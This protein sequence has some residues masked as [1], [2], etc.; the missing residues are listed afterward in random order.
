M[1]NPF[2]EACRNGDEKTARELYDSDKSVLNL[3][4]WGDYMHVVYMP[5]VTGL[6]VS[7]IEKH[8]SITSWLLSLPSLDVNMKF[9]PLLFTALHLAVSRDGGSPLELLITLTKLASKETIN[10]KTTNDADGSVYRW[11]GCTALDIAVKSDQTS[12]AIYLSWLGAQ[13]KEENRKFGDV[14]LQTWL[15]SGCQQDAP[16]WA[17]AANDLKALR[18]LASMAEVIL[19]KPILLKLAKLFG[20]H[21][22]K[23]FLEDNQNLKIYTN[24]VFCDFEITFKEINFPC[25]K[26][27]LANLSG[28]FQ[29]LIEDKKRK[30][31]P[32]K[33]ELL[34]C[35]NEAVA[36]SF[37]KF[38][39]IGAIDQDLLEWHSVS[40]LHL[41]D[42]YQV[43]ELHTIV[44]DA[45][46][47]QLCKEN[48]KELLIA[49][50]KYQSARVKAASFDFLYKNR[51]VWSE[52]IEEWKPY[53]SRELMCEIII[54]LA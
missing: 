17:V 38:F 44:E 9:G 13:C 30:N 20:R 12:I 5:G 40:F 11:I 54:K 22:I 16:M 43:K 24:Q 21:E 48:V 4:V 35:P 28:P 41:A 46:I 29:G 8:Y 18:K 27:F 39:Y 3:K 2:F 47:A 36:E 31:L 51:G 52:N 14:T 23:C 45:M 33:T 1:L 50:D 37:V 10:L 34:N 32:M 26:N 7:M 53:I 15:D 42:F 6:I 49:A 25:H 19:D